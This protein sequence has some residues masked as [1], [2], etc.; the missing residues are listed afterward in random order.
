MP[1]SDFADY[2]ERKI[3]FKKVIPFLSDNVML[4]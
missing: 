2:E 1:N 3:M 4:V